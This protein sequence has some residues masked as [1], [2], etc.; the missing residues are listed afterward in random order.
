MVAES[1]TSSSKSLTQ[2]KRAAT[3]R[4]INTIMERPYRTTLSA[5]AVGTQKDVEVLTEPAQVA[6]EC[7]DYGTRRFGFVRM[8]WR[9]AMRCMP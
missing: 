4:E 7:C 2:R 3:K 8:T 1:G 9:S 5:V 6:R